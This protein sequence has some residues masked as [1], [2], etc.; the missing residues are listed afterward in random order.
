MSIHMDFF[1]TL[2][3]HTVKGIIV[4][5]IIVYCSLEFLNI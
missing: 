1:I 4:K 2:E 5:G 3:I